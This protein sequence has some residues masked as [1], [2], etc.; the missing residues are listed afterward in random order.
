M[1]FMKLLPA[2]LLLMLALPTMAQADINAETR[3]EAIKRI[4]EKDPS[5]GGGAY[6][7]IDGSTASGNASG[8]PDFAMGDSAWEEFWVQDIDFRPFMG[9]LKTVLQEDPQ[10]TG[11]MGGDIAT[12]L[13]QV[14]F[15]NLGTS[16]TEMAI[17]GDDI[18]FFCSQTYEGL[19]EDS[20]PARLAA[21]ENLPLASYN[22]VDDGEFIMYMGIQHLPERIMIQLDEMMRQAEMGEDME[23]PLS[24]VFSEMD[25]EELEQT[26][27]LM[28][29]MQIDK[30]V[31]STL[32]GEMGI[33]LFDMPGIEMLANNGNIEPT[34]ITAAVALGIKD[35]AYVREMLGTYGSE[36]GM[37]PR[38]DSGANGW[39]VFDVPMMP[40]MG[41]LMNDSMLVATTNV[42]FAMGKLADVRDNP[43]GACQAHLAVNMA[44][45]NSLFIEPGMGMLAE[46][47]TEGDEGI[48]FPADSMKYLW[49]VPE[50]EGLGQ[51]TITARTGDAMSSEIKMKKAVFQYL[52]YYLTTIGAGAVQ[53]EMN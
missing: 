18:R 49:D 23:G 10:L 8:M 50:E 42:D 22:L 20:S 30:I 32:S 46:E 4:Q 35:P 3:A 6:A 17:T 33:A 14:Y 27:Q 31:E 9:R 43:V 24:E 52:M 44:A 48:Y 2:A 51:F 40:G 37:T 12:F 45:L 36:V 25:V 53:S 34:D 28:K 29:A 13:D 41:L 19:P 15:F 39:D 38:A 26:M 21:L 16:H 7:E 47:I 1:S 11:G 5:Y